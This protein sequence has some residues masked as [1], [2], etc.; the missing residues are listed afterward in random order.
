MGCRME[1]VVGLLNFLIEFWLIKDGLKILIYL[2]GFS[3]FFNSY[4]C[5]I[6]DRMLKGNGLIN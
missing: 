3:Y 6:I 4:H 1:I 5:L 2:F